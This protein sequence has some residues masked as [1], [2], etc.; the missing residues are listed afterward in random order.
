[1]RP[2]RPTPLADRTVVIS[3][4]GSGIGRSLAE[5]L[6]RHGCPVAMIDSD[7]ASL[8]ETEALLDGPTFAR[9][10][11]VRAA[12]ELVEFAAEVAAWM[13]TPIGAVFNNA[14]VGLSS[15]V[16]TGSPEQD[17]RAMAINFGGVVN[18]T[19][20][21]LPL[22]LEQG[23]GAIV[24]TSSIFGLMGVR[25]QSAYC[26]SKFAVRGFTEALRLELRGTGVRASLVY[27][28]G[29]KTNM[30][31][32]ATL[33]PSVGQDLDR[34]YLHREFQARARTT[35]ERA[36]QLIHDGVDRG[37][38]RILIGRDARIVDLLVR[39]APVRATDAIEALGRIGR[40]RS[41]S[42]GRDRA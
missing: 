14:G 5:R 6:A 39:L 19:R 13:P 18:G 22:M 41:A 31:R 15:S 37:S 11:D 1:M 38:A 17:E 21:F 27:P 3:G 36:A 2:R 9:A 35:P 24:N 16:A 25:N 30:I 12:V 34:E 32:H 26:A 23:D 29:V 10:L 40:A 33:D 8:Q 7:A 28:G 42:A 4:A 20:A